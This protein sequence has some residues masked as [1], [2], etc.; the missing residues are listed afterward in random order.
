MHLWIRRLLLLGFLF[1][2]LRYRAY[3]LDTESQLLY[4]LFPLFLSSFFLVEKPI[5]AFRL[6]DGLL[7]LFL[8]FFVLSMFFAQQPFGFF[9]LTTFFGGALV[10]LAVRQFQVLRFNYTELFV[11]LGALFSVYA[12]LHFLMFPTDR[13]SGFFHGYEV[14]TFYPNAAALFLLAVLPFNVRLCV[15]G[16]HFWLGVLFLNFSAFLLTFSR[17][18]YLVLLGVALLALI[19]FV[20]KLFSR[21]GLKHLLLLSLVGLL[22]VS[23]AFGLNFVKADGLV[24]TDRLLLKDDAGFA[25]VSERVDFWKGAWEMSLDHPWTGVGPGG[26]GA[27][28]PAYQQNWLAISD[29]PHNVL[30]KL[31][32]E[33]GFP[34]ALLFAGFL[35]AVFLPVFRRLIKKASGADVALFLAA[36]SL[37]LHNL[38]DYN[39]NFSVLSAL[40]FV[41]LALQ[42]NENEAHLKKVSVAGVPWS[43]VFGGLCLGLVFVTCWQGAG[44]VQARQM[45]RL[46]EVD[47]QS[48]VLRLYIENPPTLP[49]E[50]SHF[51]LQADLA[52]KLGKTEAVEAFLS[53]FD[54]YRGYHRWVYFQTR[55]DSSVAPELLKANAFN[56]MEYYFLYYSALPL[57]AENTRAVDDL[58]R[59]YTALLAQNAHMTL[60]SQNPKYTDALCELYGAPL[61]ASCDAFEQ[62]W[63]LETY[64]FNQRY[65]TQ[66]T[67][68]PL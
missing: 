13:L 24:V 54:E 6:S 17:G 55:L 18:A 39:L 45:E 58:V 38:I 57:S 27:L 5:R 64:K 65:G 2:A 34:A 33:A 47:P 28:Y 32:S 1:A 25:S 62:V 52:L 35:V 51:D 23:F 26:F 20:R 53:R 37:L 12:L 21:K 41:L 48:E 61:Q 7:L 49:F 50:M 46:Y 63:S 68:D 31:S 29:H 14:Y 4:G 9:E 16:K 44:L 67:L 10:Y 59:Y 40:F 56:E 11:G 66:L 15:E 60:L 19:F 8:F 42:E 43:F 30:L 36:L 22:S 3:L